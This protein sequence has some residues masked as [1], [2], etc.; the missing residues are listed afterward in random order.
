MHL[1]NVSSLSTTF[2]YLICLW[3]HFLLNYIFNLKMLEHAYTCSTNNHKLENFNQVTCRMPFCN[4]NCFL[5]WN[6]F[7]RTAWPKNFRRVVAVATLLILKRCNKSLNVIN[8]T[9]TIFL[10]CCSALTIEFRDII[11]MNYVINKIYVKHY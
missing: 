3:W 5:N 1:K 4:N 9:R 2:C 11:K 6:N 10:Q 8:S 7:M